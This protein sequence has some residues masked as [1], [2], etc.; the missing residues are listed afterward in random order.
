MAAEQS[1]PRRRALI[2][3]SRRRW[4]QRLRAGE[5]RLGRHR[6][7]QAPDVRSSTSGP[8]HLWNNTMRALGE[9]GSPTG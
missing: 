3:G 8:I 4:R 7:E 9:P 6:P 5:G 1:T 2:V